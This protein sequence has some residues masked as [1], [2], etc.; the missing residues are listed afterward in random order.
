[1]TD[2]AKKPGTLPVPLLTAMLVPGSGHAPGYFVIDQGA[3]VAAHVCT[4]KKKKRANLRETKAL[5]KELRRR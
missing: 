1:M 4:P 2:L 5:L 3:K